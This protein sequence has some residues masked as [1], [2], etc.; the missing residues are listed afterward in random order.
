[1][2]W[3]VNAPYNWD[4]VKIEAGVALHQVEDEYIASS[5]TWASIVDTPI[6]Y[7]LEFRHR[8]KN[9]SEDVVQVLDWELSYSVIASAPF[10]RITSGTLTI[11]GKCAFIFIRASL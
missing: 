9:T 11:S 6:K 5:W 10:G 7:E 2:C 4:K 8:A 1:L 3:Y